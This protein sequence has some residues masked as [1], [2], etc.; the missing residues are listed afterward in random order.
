M[1]PRA[2]VA[3]PGRRRC[4]SWSA[5]ARRAG[6]AETGA[7]RD[8]DTVSA[9]DLGAGAPR[10]ASRGTN[11]RLFPLLAVGKVDA[12]AS[13]LG[14]DAMPSTLPL[15]SDAMKLPSLPNTTRSDAKSLSAP[16]GGN[17]HS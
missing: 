3:G 17:S 13:L 8:D 4:V 6:L 9:L 15:L 5:G 7:N 12:R 10:S 1:L 14:S 2:L 11:G 16:S